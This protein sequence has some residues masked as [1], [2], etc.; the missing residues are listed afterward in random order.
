[1]SLSP[2]QLKSRRRWTVIVIRR[3]G[4]ISSHEISGFWVR[5]LF[6]FILLLMGLSGFLIHQ[7]QNLL[8][9][10]QR[11]LAQRV[12][13]PSEAEADKVAAGP[14]EV[15]AEPTPG[16]VDRPV[17]K[18]GA[19]KAAPSQP[20]AKTAADKTAPAS[21]SAQATLTG[22]VPPSGPA[23]SPPPAASPGPTAAA[24]P[25]PASSP[26]APAGPAEPA[27]ASPAKEATEET[28]A[29][30]GVKE[31]RIGVDEVKITKSASPKGVKFSFRL[32]KRDQSGK[33]MAGYFFV[34]AKDTTSRTAIDSFPSNQT[35]DGVMPADYSKGVAFSISQFKTIRGRVTSK[36]D[37]R[38]VMILV[39]DQDGRLILNQTHQVGSD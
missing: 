7:N 9:E 25:S 20:P 22:P 14:A 28:P 12:L 36:E 31:D 15:Q 18:A 39:Y 34:L 35:F 4:R 17:L 13:P 8:A 33:R 26:A 37:F 3:F 19:E 2:A 11:L 32:F 30:Q 24:P 21:P 16:E 10:R 27:S 38:E 6:V 5:A 23:P 1:M 29:A